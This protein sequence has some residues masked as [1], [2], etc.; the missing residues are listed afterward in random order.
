MDSYKRSFRFQEKEGRINCFFVF[1][2]FFMVIIFQGRTYVRDPVWFSAAAKGFGGAACGRGLPRAG[3]TGGL[4]A[5]RRFLEASAASVIPIETL[6]TSRTLRESSFAA[7][8]CREPVV[9]AGFSAKEFFGG[10]RVP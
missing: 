8:D 9:L 2:V 4:S 7:G 5:F 3:C 10:F 1:Y 6:R